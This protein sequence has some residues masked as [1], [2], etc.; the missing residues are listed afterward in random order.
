MVRQSDEDDLPEEHF[1]A[2]KS[3]NNQK[4]ANKTLGQVLLP[5]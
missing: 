1:V 2:L 3:I 5:V 4:M